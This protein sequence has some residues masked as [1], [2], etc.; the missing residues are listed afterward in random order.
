MKRSYRS[1]LVILMVASGVWGVACQPKPKISTAPGPTRE[2]L[3]EAHADSLRAAEEAVRLAREKAEAERRQREAAER[4]R[5]ETEE[6]QRRAAEEAAR[7]AALNTIYFEYDQSNI[8]NDQLPV[9]AENA[10]KLKEYQPTDK[11]LIEGHCD[12]RGTV[13]YNL[14]LGERRANAVKQYLINAGIDPKRVST[15]SYGKERP[16]DPGHTESAWAKNRQAELKRQGS[17]SVSQGKGR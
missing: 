15:I 1:S 7:Q 11:V 4:Q 3:E 13:E 17:P 16:V 12:E 14:T 9:L 10:K 5:R 2:Q 8:R 6:A